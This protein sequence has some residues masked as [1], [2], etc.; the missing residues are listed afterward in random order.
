M[1][2]VVVAGIYGYIAAAETVQPVIIEKI[3][4]TPVYYP[5]YV[6]SNEIRHFVNIGDLESYLLNLRCSEEFQ[7]LEYSVN[8]FDCEDFAD[9]LCNK[10]ESDN[11]RIDRQYR[12]DH[13]VC[14]VTFI[15]SGNVVFVEPQSLEIMDTWRLDF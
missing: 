15:G 14:S 13:V 5:S 3:H 6:Y 2:A 12:K 4:E 10:A 1:L 11:L 9:W 7:S 8:G